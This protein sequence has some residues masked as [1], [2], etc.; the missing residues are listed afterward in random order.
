M[1]NDKSIKQ[2]AKEA[3]KRLK[4]SFWQEYKNNVKNGVIKAE[5][6]GT[7]PSKVVEYYQSKASVTVRGIKSED[8]EFYLKVKELLLSVGEVSD[9]IGRLTDKDYFNTLTYEQKQRYTFE[10][11][12]KYVKAK[13][14]FYRE[15][16]YE[17]S[18]NV[19]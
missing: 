1:Q 9:A 10:I 4:S 7:S 15:V 11:S 8:E 5:E 12:S 6:D 3:K 2:Y 17:N 16:E 14:R 18:T 19:K 13:E